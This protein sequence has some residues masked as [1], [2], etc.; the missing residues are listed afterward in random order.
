MKRRTLYECAH[1]RVLIR[2]I[3]CRRGFSL[4]DKSGSGHIDIK[5][6]ARGEELALAP[7][8]KCTDYDCLGPP[9]PPPERGWQS[10]KEANR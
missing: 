5:R 8:Q 3:Y 4:S 9:V 6:L 1:A 2:R 7:C 10:K